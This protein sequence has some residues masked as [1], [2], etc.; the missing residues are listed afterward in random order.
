MIVTNNFR[1]RRTVKAYDNHTLAENRSECNKDSKPVFDS[2]MGLQ[3]EKQYYFR[4]IHF[5][6]G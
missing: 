6:W 1:I 5:V 4:H 3:K 2:G